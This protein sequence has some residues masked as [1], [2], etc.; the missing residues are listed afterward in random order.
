MISWFQQPPTKT[1]VVAGA[2]I[3]VAVF[4]VVLVFMPRQADKA[5]T[6]RQVLLEAMSRGYRCHEAGFSL[7]AC[8]ANQ[9]ERWRIV[10]SGGQVGGW[11][12]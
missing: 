9:R 1:E 11:K 4:A 7:E 6:T 5:E 10:E 3:S 2:A 8:A 12:P